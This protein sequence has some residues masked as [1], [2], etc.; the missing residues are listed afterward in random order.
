VPA[1]LPYSPQDAAR[2]LAD[3]GWADA[4]GNG[5]LEKNGRELRFTLS[6]AGNVTAEAIFVQEQLR[7]VGVR[8]DISTYQD[9]SVLERSLR[10]G[11]DFDA[12]IVHYN[13]VEQ[14]GKFPYTGFRD[15]EISALR[16]STWF[17]IDHATVD[18]HLRSFWRRFAESLPVTY[19][20]PSVDYF[21]AHRRVRGL[22]NDSE[23]FARVE[24]LWFEDE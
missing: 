20:H 11:A 13:F 21:V 10:R 17:A 15:D 12:A 22:A 19:L 6:A 9:R 18:R 5:V 16:D 3:A 8:V 23:L 1:A 7:R 2:L 14:F 24:H 4:D